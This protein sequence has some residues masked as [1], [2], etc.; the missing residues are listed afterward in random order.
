MVF[1]VAGVFGARW[2]AV[3]ALSEELSPQLAWLLSEE[4]QC[5]KL[6]ISV[7]VTW[8]WQWYPGRPERCAGPG[9]TRTSFQCLSSSRVCLHAHNVGPL[10]CPSETLHLLLD[11]TPSAPGSDAWS[12]MGLFSAHPSAS[13]VAYAPMG[14]RAGKRRRG[15]EES[16]GIQT[17]GVYRGEHEY[18]LCLWDGVGLG[19]IW[20]VFSPSSHIKLKPGLSGCV[21]VFV[22]VGGWH[23]FCVTACYLDFS[24]EIMTHGRRAFL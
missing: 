3:P 7:R 16:D 23:T 14:P 10:D 24:F 2:K 11:H 6:K 20:D 21:K 15:M 1:I 5:R 8:M 19:W 18:P 17:W 22:K 9:Q 4:S 13:A 12:C